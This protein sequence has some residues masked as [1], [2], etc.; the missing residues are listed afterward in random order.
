MDQYH[1]HYLQ[2]RFKLRQPLSGKASRIDG[3]HHTICLRY[4]PIVVAVRDDGES[5]CFQTCQCR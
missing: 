1:H 4:E 3:I 2:E 5:R